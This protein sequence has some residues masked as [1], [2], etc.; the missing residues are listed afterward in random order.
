MTVAT[1]FAV[2]WNPLTNSKLNASPSASNRKNPLIR[3]IVCPKRVMSAPS[4]G[5]LLTA[6]IARMTEP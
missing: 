2:S 4:G 6:G 5:S 1:A 3:E